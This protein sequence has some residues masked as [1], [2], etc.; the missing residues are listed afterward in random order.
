M[1]KRLLSEGVTREYRERQEEYFRKKGMTLLVDIVFKGK[2][3]SVKKVYFT[4]VYRCDQ[5]IIDSLCLA[6]TALDKMKEEFP[7]L[8]E[9]YAKSDD[10]SSY[11]GEAL[12]QLC[13]ERQIKLR[14]Y[15]YSEP[16][17]GKDQ[18]DHESAGARCVLRSY[19]D[20]GMIY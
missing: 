18:C 10:A 8:E 11:H 19:V 3:E 13:C 5:G 2:E 14:R 16:S 1:A 15:N 12:Y 20:A 17:H 7:N 9:L 4:T 6:T